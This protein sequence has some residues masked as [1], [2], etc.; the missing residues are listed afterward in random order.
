M[1]SHPGNQNYLHLSYCMSKFSSFNTYKN[2]QNE[3]TFKATISSYIL[4]KIT[5]FF[6]GADFCFFLIFILNNVWSKEVQ[7]LIN[8]LENYD[9]TQRIWNVSDITEHFFTSKISICHSRNWNSFFPKKLLIF[10][11]IIILYLP[12]FTLF[13]SQ[14]VF[15]V[16]RGQCYKEICS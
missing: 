5:V 4:I 13:F 8:F 9:F 14:K 12:F 7:R 10:K 15:F 11:V 1:N 2:V 6:E 16:Y 3:I